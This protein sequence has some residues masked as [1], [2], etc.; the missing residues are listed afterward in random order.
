MSWFSRDCPRRMQGGMAPPCPSE[1][2]FPAPILRH[3]TG[4]C[5]PG[6]P[7]SLFC[8][9]AT[10]PWPVLNSGPWYMRRDCNLANS[11]VQDSKGISNQPLAHPCSS[12]ISRGSSLGPLN[13]APVGP[14]THGPGPLSV[15]PLQH[16][17]HLGQPWSTSHL[18]MERTPHLSPGNAER[19][20]FVNIS[21]GPSFI[22]PFLREVR[23]NRGFMLLG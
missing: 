15:R 17:P 19:K 16:W 5:Y 8:V 7:K 14:T 11:S 18:P 9:H 13:L 6:L 1:P 21:S 12:A 23:T 4:I 22:C 10:D 2:R 3:V 20:A